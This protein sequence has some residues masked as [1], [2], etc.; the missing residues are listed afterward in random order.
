MRIRNL[1]SYLFMVIILKYNNYF[2]IYK[3]DYTY[4]SGFA[5]FNKNVNKKYTKYLKF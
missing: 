2:V 1:A 5:N 4:S 3:C